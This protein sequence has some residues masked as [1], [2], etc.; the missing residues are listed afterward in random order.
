M[1]VA[2]G[3]LAW[4]LAAAGTRGAAIAGALS[5]VAAVVAA[6]AAVWPLLGGAGPVDGSA[7]VT[8]SPAGVRSK[9]P[10]AVPSKAR[11]LRKTKGNTRLLPALMSEQIVLWGPPASGKTCFLAALTAAAVQAN[12]PWNLFGLTRADSSFIDYCTAEMIG[13]RRFPQA[14]MPG[15]EYRFRGTLEGEYAQQVRRHQRRQF[16][17][18]PVRLEL[19]ILDV[20]GGVFADDQHGYP[21]ALREHLLDNLAASNGI[22]FFFDPL[23]EEEGAGIYEYFQVV[24]DQLRSRLRASNG[25]D[26]SYLPHR[27]AVC[28]AK[29]DDQKVLEIARNGGYIAG[30]LNGADIFPRIADDRAEAFFDEL[31]S[32][33]PG[34]GATLF[35]HAVRRFFHPDKIRY[36]AVSSIGFY[37]EPSGQFNWTNCYNV[38]KAAEAPWKIRGNIHPI[39]VLEPLLWLG[40]SIPG[41]DA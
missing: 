29:Y 19:S 37:L 16:V 30:G 36:F 2:L 15:V 18:S 31:C 38:L 14:S 13:N 5:A 40:D 22:V 27:V 33:S 4:W 20:P 25:L 12:P 23:R 34:G 6:V 1:C 8:P 26:G 7:P 21:G 39:N 28:I 10:A 11:V 3:C 9:S 24:V 35:G 41:R 32:R 17:S